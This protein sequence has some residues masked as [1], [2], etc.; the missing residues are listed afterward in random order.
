MQSDH[1]SSA[2]SF[3]VSRKQQ[4]SWLSAAYGIAHRA[5]YVAGLGRYELLDTRAPYH[6]T[7]GLMTAGGKRKPAWYAYQRAR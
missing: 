7:G 1:A 3:F 5:S 4:A 6:L 2:F